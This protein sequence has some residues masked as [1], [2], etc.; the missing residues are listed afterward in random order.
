MVNLTAEEKLL[1]QERVIIIL[2]QQLSPKHGEMIVRA[3]FGQAIEELYEEQKQGR[4]AS[5]IEVEGI[6]LDMESALGPWS[7]EQRR[8]AK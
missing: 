4:S 6:L 1:I 7:R 5:E 3:A 8:R 2:A